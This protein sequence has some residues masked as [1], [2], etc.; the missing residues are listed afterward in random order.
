MQRLM[1][2]LHRRDPSAPSELA[3]PSV[4]RAP[5]GRSS[6]VASSRAATASSGASAS[7]STTTTTTSSSSSSGAGTTSCSQVIAVAITIATSIV[8]IVVVVTVAKPSPA[9]GAAS[10]SDNGNGTVTVG[11]SDSGSATGTGGTSTGGGGSSGG[12]NPW[13]CTSTS[14][15]LNDEGGFAPGGPTP[16]GWYS[17]TCNNGVT[18][19]STTQTVWITSQA[20]ATT[21]GVDPRT[22]AL[23]AEDSLR[24]PS[25]TLHFNPAASAVVNLPTWLWVDP[26]VWHPYSVT[27]SV[28]AVSATAVATPVAVTWQMGDGGV[29]TC[30]GPGQA[31][32]LFRP[33][34]MQDTACHYA[35]RTSSLGQPFTDGNPDTAAYLVRAT[36]TWTVS[37]SAVGAA[38]QGTLPSLATSAVTPVR[39]VQVESVDTGPSGLFGLSSPRIAEGGGP[40]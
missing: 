5:S 34:Q 3:D 22:V 25:P 37:W 32:D 12:A 35:Y 17:I 20:P 30:A 19:A 28:G 2:K 23:Q 39:V 7:F 29:V 40:S 6:P 31:F 21:P 16:G 1:S 10:G 24:L 26:S 13:T 9:F 14:L 18:G 15:I 38:G 36:I 11:V 33:A 27:A 4:R 8:V